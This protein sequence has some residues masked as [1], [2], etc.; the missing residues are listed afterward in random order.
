MNKATLTRFKNWIIATNPNLK[1]NESVSTNSIYLE[2]DEIRIRISDHMPGL[3][4]VK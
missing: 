2:S 1:L 4:K 3:S